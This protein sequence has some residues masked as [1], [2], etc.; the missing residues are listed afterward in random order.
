MSSVCLA[1]AVAASNLNSK[2]MLY[3]ADFGYMF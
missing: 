1:L 2:F 3:L